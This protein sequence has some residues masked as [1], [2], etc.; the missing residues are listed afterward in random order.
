MNDPGEFGHTVRAAL[1][2]RR[3]SIRAAAR[4]L[5][6]DHAYL[7]RVLSGN[8]PPSSQLADGLDR[9]LATGGA[10]AELAARLT[11]TEAGER[12]AHAV[13]N[14]TRVDA[15]AVEVLADVLAAQ[16]RLDDVMGPSPLIGPTESRTAMLLDLLKGAR[17]PHRDALV[18]VAAESVQFVGW[19]YAGTRQ[20]AKAIPRLDEAADLADEAGSGT[21]AAQAC[22]FR[23]YISRQQGN[24]RG[25]VRWFSA[26]YRTHGAH[27]A[28]RMGDAAQVAQGLGE[29]GETDQARRLLDEAMGLS[30]AAQ[31]QPPGT[32][33]WLTPNFQ[34][35]NLGLAHLGLK[36]FDLAA[37]HITAGLG[38]L[39]ADQQGAEW[40]K[41]HRGA[42]AQAEAN[43]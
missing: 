35:L 40:T 24:P 17:G 22:N 2:D 18:A 30:D 42:L 41:E 43:R 19:L 1:N 29:L 11:E 32:A 37:D 36:E 15:K 8:Q 28:Q 21:L 9:L 14:P 10:L 25:M 13:A 26:A 4:A 34:R 3:M 38:G 16:R 33:Y 20:V 39:P 7:C 6:Y 23:G 27:P 5:H 31:D 12:I